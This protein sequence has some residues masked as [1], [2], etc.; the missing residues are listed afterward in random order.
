[1]EK[2]FQIYKKNKKSFKRFLKSF[3]YAF[4]G[5]RYAFYHEQNLIVMFV[6]AIIA[7]ILGMILKINYIERL[8]IVLLIG[9]VMTLEMLNT[10][11]ESVVNLYD[12]DKK[13]ENGKIA[14]DCASGAVGIACIISLIVYVMIFLPKIIEILK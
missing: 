14:K 7:I 4:S 13:E 12:K 11:I 8:V 2:D 10:A 3:K 6:M 9:I 5:M 1:M